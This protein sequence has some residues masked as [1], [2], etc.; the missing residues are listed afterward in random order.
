MD[1][2]IVMLPTVREPDGLAM[3]SRNIYLNPQQRQEAAVLYQ[4]LSLAKKLWS[5]GEKKAEHLR[6]EMRKFI[7]KQTLMEIDYISIASTDTLIE[8]EILKPPI[9]V[10]LAVRFGNIRLIDNLILQ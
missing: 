2:E 1:L 7:E 8:L 10:S 9:L 3:S 6:Q 4:A 5:H